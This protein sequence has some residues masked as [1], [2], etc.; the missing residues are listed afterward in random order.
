MSASNSKYEEMNER[1]DEFIEYMTG[2]GAITT[3]E[4]TEKFLMPYHMVYSTM[5]WLMEDGLVVKE[6]FNAHISTYRL[7]SDK[8]FKHRKPIFGSTKGLKHERVKFAP[9]DYPDM[10]SDLARMMGYAKSKPMSGTVYDMD[11]F[12]YMSSGQTG[13]SKH[14]YGV[15]PVY[16]E[17]F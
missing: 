8:K 3:K 12:N 14:S 13:K 1:C 9:V 5:D 2:K 16:G 7:I 6:K 10:P 11:N 17:S 4:F 15:S